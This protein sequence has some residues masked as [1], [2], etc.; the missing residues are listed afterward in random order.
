MKQP[1]ITASTVDRYHHLG[2]QGRRVDLEGMTL[3]QALAVLRNIDWGNL[4]EMLPVEL[5]DGT[6]LSVELTASEGGYLMSSQ[7]IKRLEWRDGGCHVLK[8]RDCGYH[9]IRSYKI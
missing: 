5:S 1:T 9:T 7:R 2:D 6:E 8:W 3:K 4:G